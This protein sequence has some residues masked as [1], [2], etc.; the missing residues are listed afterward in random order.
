[1]EY[2]VVNEMTKKVTIGGNPI[3]RAIPNKI[4]TIMLVTCR[5]Q[6]VAASASSGVNSAP[7]VMTFSNRLVFSLSWS[8]RVSFLSLISREELAEI[9][10]LA[11]MSLSDD[12][13]VFP[14][15]DLAGIFDGI[16]LVLR[17]HD[18]VHEEKYLLTA[19][20]QFKFCLKMT[21]TARLEY[22][23]N[24]DPSQ[25]KCSHFVLQLLTLLRLLAG[26]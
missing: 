26:F 24:N 25:P 3:I 2:G 7:G 18:T 13:D 4:P 23:K 5:I 12:L 17:Q 19:V 9:P 10:V 11:E 1:M 8:G 15:L 22:S 20:E 21:T 14:L 16:E 6:C